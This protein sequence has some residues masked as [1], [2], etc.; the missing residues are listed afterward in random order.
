M[1]NV[2]RSLEIVFVVASVLGLLAAVFLITGGQLTKAQSYPYPSDPYPYPYPE[3]TKP[4]CGRIDHPYI[5]P[6]PE[7][8]VYLPSALSNLDGGALPDPTSTPT[9]TLAPSPTPL[10]TPTNTPT[11]TATAVPNP[12]P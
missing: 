3:P 8:C 11:P 4:K 12:Y 5:G 1:V 9:P 7:A 10:P 2:K 6:Y